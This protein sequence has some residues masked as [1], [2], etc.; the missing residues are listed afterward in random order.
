MIYSARFLAVFVLVNKLF[1]FK[2]SKVIH[3]G[4]TQ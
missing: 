1:K 3:T 4:Y 2:P